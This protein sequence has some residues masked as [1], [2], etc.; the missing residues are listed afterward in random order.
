M[1][2]AN[3]PHSPNLPLGLQTLADQ[4]VDAVKQPNW[5]EQCWG[6]TWPTA[7]ALRAAGL[8]RIC[9]LL[10]LRLGSP[11]CGAYR[12]CRRVFP[13]NRVWSSGAWNQYGLADIDGLEE[14][15]ALASEWEV[16]DFFVPV[17]RVGTAREWLLRTKREMPRIGALATPVQPKPVEALK[18]YLSL[19][20]ERPPEPEADSPDEPE[21]FGAVG[22]YLLQTPLEKAEPDFYWSHLLP[23]IIR[24]SA[25]KPR[26]IG[27]DG[28]PLTSS[29]SS[30]PAGSW[31][32]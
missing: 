15:L 18:H 16:E 29:Q 9:S 13:R 27:A 26:R 21:Q 30:A 25:V 1:L 11:G 32:C 5:R 31:P 14:K 28:N 12:P 2:E 20:T 24:A 22:V 3:S 10:R 4:V 23:W 19:L 7:W 8:T 6:L 17:W